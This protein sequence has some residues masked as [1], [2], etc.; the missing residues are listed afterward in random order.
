[1]LVGMLLQLVAYPSFLT[2]ML[3]QQCF[4]RIDKI[5]AL[6]VLLLQAHLR[7][8][9]LSRERDLL[10]SW[11]RSSRLLPRSRSLQHNT[12]AERQMGMARDCEHEVGTFTPVTS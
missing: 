7:L 6:L 10:R 9:S 11:R 8:R 1:M 5:T 3:L 2:L 12:A 4:H